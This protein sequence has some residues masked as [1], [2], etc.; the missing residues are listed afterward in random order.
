MKVALI[1]LN[2]STDVHQWSGLNYFIARALERAGA[3]LH[4]IGPLDTRWTMAMRIRQRW[5]DATKRTYHQVMEPQSLAA[6]GAAA[7]AQIPADADAVLGVTS[8]IAAAVGP[9]DLPF[10]SWDD[11]TSAAMSE[12]YPDFERL[13][14]VSRQHNIEVGRRAVEAV[15]LAIYSSDWAANS[16]RA[17]YGLPESRVA[18]VPF[19]ANLEEL[20]SQG[21]VEAAIAARPDNVCRLLWVGVEWH[22]KGGPLTI[23]IARG[24]RDAGVNVE[25]TLVGCKPELEGPPED[26]MRI[27]GFVSKKTA[28]GR[29]R[30]AEL[31]LRSHFFVMPSKAEAYGLVYVEAATYGVPAVAIHTGGV[32][33]IIRDDLTGILGTPDSDASQYVGRILS[34]LHDPDRYT[35]MALAARKR[36][37]DR[38]NWDTAGRDVL[39]RLDQLSR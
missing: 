16:A 30:L 31:F 15:S 2:D 21:D 14:P 38:L 8:L 39:A 27:E 24:L 13:A 9:L 28:A 34:L 4:R 10:A 7:R 12:Y 35:N 19:G 18:V 11:A 37:T 36:A 33:T 32:P 6:I 25:L 29:V 5:Y 1:T 20:P 23:E 22:R 26:W 17:A 3:T